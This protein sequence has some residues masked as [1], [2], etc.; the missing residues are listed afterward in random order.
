MDPDELAS[1]EDSSSGTTLFSQE[2]I[3]MEK[4]ETTVH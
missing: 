4:V 1:T 3:E 2:S